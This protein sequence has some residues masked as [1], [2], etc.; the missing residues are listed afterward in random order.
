MSHDGVF[1]MAH[2]TPS[3]LDEMPEYLR[4]VRGGRPP[5]DELVHEMRE[6]Y[7]AIGGRSPL[8]EITEAQA[9]A[10]RA[11]LGPDDSGRRRHAQLA[12]V[13]QGRARAPGGGRRHARHRHPAGA[14][15]LDAERAEVHRRRHRGAAGRRRSSRRSNRFTRI[16]CCSTRSPSACAPRSRRPTRRSSSPRTPAGARHR[17]GRPLRRPG[18]GDRRGRRGA[19]R[20]RAATTV[21]YP[22]RRPHAGAVDRPGARRSSS[23]SAR[24]TAR[25]GSS[26]CRSASSATTPR[27]CSTSTSRRRRPRASSRRTLRRTESLNTSPCSS[28]CSRISSGS[29]VM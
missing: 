16:R 18:R 25:A 12:P 3:S 4:L 20:H 14:A 22:E 6:N 26:S 15:V 28:R 13:H 29:D 27:S 9:A 7:G 24:R 17:G 10:L 23:T 8:T 21:A 2:G 11:R 19:R 1:L 5:S